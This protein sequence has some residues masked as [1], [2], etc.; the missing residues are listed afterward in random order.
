MRVNQIS[1]ESCGEFHALTT[2][3]KGR[4]G[5]RC[6]LK[7]TPVPVFPSENPG[8]NLSDEP[9]QN[10]KFL[11]NPPQPLW[12]NQVK[13]IFFTSQDKKFLRI[14]HVGGRRGIHRDTLTS[15]RVGAYEKPPKISDFL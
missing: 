4:I 12:K 11:S 14:M 13:V 3:V 8:S 5:I 7:G 6:R 10:Q 9:V 1:W 15:I 2:Y